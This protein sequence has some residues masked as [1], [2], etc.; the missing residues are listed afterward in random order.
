MLT[1]ESFLKEE[2]VR[3]KHLDHIEDLMVLDGQEGLDTSIAFLKD[4]H[5]SLQSGQ[6]GLGMSTKW[7][8]K[9]AVICGVNPDNGRFFVSTKAAFSKQVI[10]LH[11]EKEIRS[12][13]QIKDLADKLVEALKYL[14]KLG[15]KGVLQGD[16]MF[17]A[18]AKKTMSVKGTDYIT[19]QP[20]TILYAAPAASE[21][22]KRIARAKFG[23]VFHTAYSGSSMASLSATTFNFNAS[24]LK[25]TPDVWFADPNIY[26]LT[27]ALLTASESSTLLAQI[28]ECETL[29]KSVRPFLK[30]LIARKDLMPYLLPYVNSTIN[31]GLSQYSPSG[32]KSNI[33]GKFQKDINKLKTEKGQQGKRDALKKIT[34][35]IDAYEKQFV[36]LFELHNK[37]AKAKEI[38][39][40]KLNGVSQLGHFFVDEK[41]IQPTD[42]EGIVIV[43]SGRAVKLVNRLKFSRQNRKV[44]E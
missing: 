22:G 13:I 14:P 10:A 24:K 29:A 35:F 32:L 28:K 41:G 7:D 39:I 2:A 8:G 3:N 16:L 5:D 43:R 12:T 1:F 42:P 9:P 44:N 31:G 40:A 11:T 37:I 15:I 23:I 36:S 25:T 27:P 18:D 20:N 19:F 4:L 17:T 21:I 6:S 38:V 33:E 30:T 34:D 26:D